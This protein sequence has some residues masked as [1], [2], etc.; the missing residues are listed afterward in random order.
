M[1][2]NR[3]TLLAA[4]VVLVGCSESK[5]AEQIIGKWEDTDGTS[6]VIEFSKDGAITLTDKRNEPST[7]KYRFVG[8]NQVE[9]PDADGK[10]P[11]MTFK[12]SVS[13]DQLTM[14]K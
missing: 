7:A 4:M 6:L 5:P 3:L 8:D 12:V 11:K 1:A 13:K 2:N 9:L 14:S 10:I